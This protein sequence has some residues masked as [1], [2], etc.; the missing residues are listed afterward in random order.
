MSLETV[1]AEVRT[2]GEHSLPVRECGVAAAET[3]GFLDSHV[4]RR[5]PNAEADPTAKPPRPEA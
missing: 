2:A 1:G 3:S 5:Q 4:P